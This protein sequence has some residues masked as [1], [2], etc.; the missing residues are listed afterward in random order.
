M[1]YIPVNNE[2]TKIST[3]NRNNNRQTTTERML[4]THTLSNI[5]MTCYDMTEETEEPK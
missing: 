4:E 2:F 5:I 1:H 3:E